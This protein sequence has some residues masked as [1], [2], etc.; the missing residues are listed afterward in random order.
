MGS[1]RGAG[2]RQRSPPA[3]CARPP[4]G[5]LIL[6]AEKEILF[7]LR[8]GYTLLRRQTSAGMNQKIFFPISICLFV[9]FNYYSFIQ[10]SILFNL[11]ILYNH[12]LY[13]SIFY[14]RPR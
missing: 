3:R 13:I 10:F 6:P 12:K 2:C 11:F 8:Q 9:M 14:A 1:Q 5:A 7:S 4:P